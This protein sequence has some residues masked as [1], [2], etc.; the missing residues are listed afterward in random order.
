VSDGA[1]DGRSPRD[2]A[3]DRDL[4]RAAQRGDREA[5]ADLI[6]ARGD[7]LFAIAQRILRDVDRTEDAV[8]DALVIAWRD[9]PG[10]RDPDRFDAWL[11]RVVVRC[12][13]AEAVRR[14]RVMNNLYVLSED[15]A[16]DT[17]DYL[18][19]AVR[20]QL[21]RGFRRVPPEQR[22]LLVLRHYAGLEPSE[23]AEVLGIPPG[24]ARSRLHHAHR[25]MRAALDADARTS[26]VGG[27]V[28]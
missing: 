4:V 27:S 26:A 21:E 28:A 8:Q 3:V 6:R 12:C 16:A 20:D 24:T 9:L 25:A 17:D 1:P 14:R 15:Q 18:T 2:G 22:A 23:I 5:Y 19:V 13:I 11:H 7:R 10:L